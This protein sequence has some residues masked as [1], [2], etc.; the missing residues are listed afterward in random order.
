MFKA[1][2]RFAGIVIALF[3]ILPS[4]VNISTAKAFQ[5]SEAIDDFVNKQM[6]TADIPGLS[7]GIVK[8]DQIVY[9]KGYGKADETNRSITPQTPF[10]LGSVSKTFT[11]LA[12]RQLVNQGK[13]ELDRPVRDYISWFKLSDQDASRQITIRNLLDHKSGIPRKADYQFEL[14][15]DR[16][17]LVQTVQMLNR[18]K[19]DRPVGASYEYANVNYIILGLAVQTV[20]GQP[21]EEYVKKNIFDPL[22][23]KNSFSSESE[24]LNDRMAKGYQLF[25]GFQLP[26]RVPYPKAAL[27]AG[28]LISSSEDMAHYMIA[29]LGNGKYLNSYITKESNSIGKAD[30]G[31]FGDDIYTDIYWNPRA[32]IV[33]NG[34]VE[35]AGSTFNYSSELIVLPKEKWGVVVLANTNPGALSTATITPSSIAIGIIKQYLVPQEYQP[36]V[37]NIKKVYIVLDF[38]MLLILLLLAVQIRNL[39]KKR[40]SFC[41]SRLGLLRYIIVLIT[42]NFA[43]PLGIL[44]GLPRLFPNDENPS[45]ALIALGSPDIAYFCI[46]AS[47]LLLAV[48]ILKAIH[49]MLRSDRPLAAGTAKKFP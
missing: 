10:I 13:I 19:L 45:W 20:S 49:C 2:L 48:G 40:N 43:L 39:I 30:Q 31:T 8:N 26:R 33:P 15:N 4:A 28:Y 24:A 21:Y 11:A 35:H 1:K 23:M 42:V 27:P 32:G 6:N 38:V 34:C 41:R 44:F 25:F 47:V 22:Q 18:V 3:C 12:I 14:F 16:Y 17:D 37:N 7:F 9:L 36:A 5:Y 29:Y 46:I